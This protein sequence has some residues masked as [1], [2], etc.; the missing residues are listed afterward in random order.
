AGRLMVDRHKLIGHLH[1]LWWWALDNVGADGKLTGLGIYEI[2]TAA[3]WDGDP[4]EFVNALVAAGFIDVNPDGMALHD[5]YE[6][7]W[8]SYRHF[9]EVATEQRG[10]CN[11][12]D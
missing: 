5:W 12:M 1:E 11:G 7:A 2:A 9:A 10:A 4:E 6:Y 3:Q 8:R